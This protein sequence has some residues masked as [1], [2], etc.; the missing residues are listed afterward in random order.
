MMHVASEWP[1]RFGAEILARVRTSLEFANHTIVV[2]AAD[3]DALLDAIDGP[4]ETGMRIVGL[5]FFEQ[6]FPAF[7]S[8]SPAL[9]VCFYGD[10]WDSAK[11]VAHSLERRVEAK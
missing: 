11:K 3:T 5:P 7:L 9:N 2:R 6:R 8:A 1:G 4:V 10:G